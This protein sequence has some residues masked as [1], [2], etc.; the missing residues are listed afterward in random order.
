M[1]VG[2]DTKSLQVTGISEGEFLK[3]GG[4]QTTFA[5]QVDPS[6]QVLIKAKRAT[7]GGMGGA[8]AAAPVTTISFRAIAP[9]DAAKVQLNTLTPTDAGGKPIAV[10]SLAPQTIRIQQ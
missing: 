9:A 1:T 6:G 7:D 8:S 10:P 2:F 3:Q 4:A 5:S